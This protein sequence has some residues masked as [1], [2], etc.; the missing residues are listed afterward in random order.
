[1]AVEVQID[2]HGVTLSQY[3]EAME[4]GGFLP[5]GPLPADGLFHYVKKIDDGIRVIN[6]WESE[7]EFGEFRGEQDAS[8]AGRNRGFGIGDRNP[9]LRDSQLPGRQSLRPL[10]P[11]LRPPGTA[12]SVFPMVGVGDHGGA[13]DGAPC[14]YSPGARGDSRQS[15]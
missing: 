15:V 2:C 13:G 3:D 7:E 14:A 6:V 5:G 8:L 4:I 10:I 1:M 9:D 12:C 11:A